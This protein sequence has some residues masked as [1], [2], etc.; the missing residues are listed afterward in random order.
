MT[1]YTATQ[2][3]T[4]VLRDLGVIDARES[5]DADDI[6]DAT[7]IISS[8]MAA[9]QIRGIPIWAGSSSAVPEE[10]LTALSRRLGLA[11]GPSYGVFSL[12]DAV[13]GID[14]AERVLRQMSAKQSS[15]QPIGVD[16]Y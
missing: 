12:A 14:A 1:T 3:A 2:L 11:I 6:S 15:G 10:Y 8:E 5:P 4:R 16:Y 13:V 9:M 7:Q